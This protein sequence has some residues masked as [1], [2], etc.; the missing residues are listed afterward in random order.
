MRSHS[1]SVSLKTVPRVLTK[2]RLDLGV[3]VGEGEGGKGGAKARKGCTFVSVEGKIN[4]Q[5]RTG[6]M[7]IRKP[8]SAVTVVY[9]CT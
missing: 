5:L 8:T 7:Y 4:N 6:L 3:R 2:Y 1:R 9:C